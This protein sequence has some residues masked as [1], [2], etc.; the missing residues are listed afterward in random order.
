VRAFENSL[1]PCE[2]GDHEF[3]V[4]IEVLIAHIR[5][6]ARPTGVSTN[7]CPSTFSADLPRPGAHADRLAGSETKS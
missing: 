6:P 1:E 7:H 4:A 2:V 3:G 5:T